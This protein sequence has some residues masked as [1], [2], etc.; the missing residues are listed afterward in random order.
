MRLVI[1]K[2]VSKE[3]IT[4]KGDF[5]VDVEDDQVH[6]EVVDNSAHLQKH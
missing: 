1:L 5:E 4:N 6:V 2:I 3:S